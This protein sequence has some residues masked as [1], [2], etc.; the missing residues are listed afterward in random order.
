MRST[1]LTIR[2]NDIK[3]VVERCLNDVKEM[4]SRLEIRVKSSTKARTEEAYRIAMYIYEQ[5]REHRSIAEIE[6]LIH[7]SLFAAS[8]DN[9]KGYYFAENMRGIEMVNR[10]NPELE[11]Q[12]LSELLDGKGTFI[13][14]EILDVARSDKKEGFCTYHWN[15]P[16]SPG[17]L[18]PK[19]SYVKYFEPLDWVIGNGIYLDDEE[20]RIKKEVIEWLGN[21]KYGEDGYVFVGNFN[22]ISYGTPGHG[23]NMWETTDTNG[24]YIVQEIVSQA[25]SGGGFVRYVMPALDG[26]MPGKKLSYAAPILDWEWFV[27]TGVY[28]DYIDAE[29]EE[30][31]LIFDKSL[32]KILIEI[33][34][35]L[36][37]CLCFSFLLSWFLVTRIK[38]NLDLFLS[39]FQ[40]SATEKLIIPLDDVYFNEFQSLAKSANRMADDRF[41]ALE[42]LRA[43]QERLA[44]TLQSIGD[45][46]ITTD[47]SGRIVLLNRVAE[48]L[49]GWKMS[50]AYGLPVADVYTIVSTKDGKKCTGPIQKVL[51]FGKTVGLESNTAL[52]ARDLERKSI[53]DSA[54]PIR[55][56]KGEML[57][58][59][60]VFR[61]VTNEKKIEQ[62][63]QKVRNLESVG[64]LAGG[65]AH[66]FNNIL[67]GII[68]NVDLAS[69]QLD[70]GH[71]VLPL[72][73]E[74][75]KASFR[76]TKLTQQLLTFSKGGAPVKETMSLEQIIVESADFALH[77]SSISCNYSF[78][79]S[80]LW[81][82]DVDSGQIGQVIQ[83]IVLNSKDAMIDGGRIEIVCSN[84]E[85]GP[86]KLRPNVIQ[87][88]Y[89]EILIKDCGIGMTP[90]ELERIFDP[91]YTNKST[92]TGLGLA[93]CHSIV[94]KHDG[95]ISVSSRYGSGTTFT[96]SLPAK[97]F[98]S[99]DEKGSNSVDKICNSGNLSIMMMDDDELVRATAKSQLTHLGH[100]VILVSDGDEAVRTYQ[101][102]QKVGH[103]VDLVIMD[104]TIPGGMGG[105]E[106][107]QRL[108][109]HDPDVKIIV[110][111]GY[112]NDP[113]MANFSE[114]GFCGAVS[115]PFDLETLGKAIDLVF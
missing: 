2:S 26:L 86:D 111:S 7:D 28:V 97:P 5:N 90:E 100:E 49:T 61:D 94:N 101:K 85:N 104:L 17:I 42:S 89:V 88:S 48:E 54:A 96:I 13:V 59:V 77:G 29:I 114:Y 21:I 115:K 83:N 107:A 34:L 81:P 50:E 25:K 87:G 27:G 47:T 12:D 31:K 45:G 19:I 71:N 82:A 67:T 102:K 18:A 79:D 15:R 32:R 105:K 62:E 11:G 53:A 98:A 103:V 65:I 33:T 9:G 41:N 110:A 58:V 30:E 109:L 43:E 39:F 35:V 3:S 91:Y 44:V 113:I 69:C 23:K 70:A 56:E 52:V 99:L 108:L 64:V 24:K 1:L 4:R 16:G 75:K 14:Q 20:E 84:E 76:A 68:G 57:G 78:P 10:N 92:G 112:S 66:D 60:L 37:V 73:K 55:G 8:W 40:K 63:L 106:A 93:I 6:T 38:I 72:L 51:R 46:V 95:V 22:G 36:A 80:N 74:A